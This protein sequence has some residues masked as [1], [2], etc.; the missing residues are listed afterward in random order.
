[1]LFLFGLLVFRIAT[2]SLFAVAGD[3]V[4]PVVFGSL[5]SPNKV[6]STSRWDR[7]NGVC[8]LKWLSSG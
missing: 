2:W 7:F 4:D 6:T 1:M 5:L 3:P 8:C